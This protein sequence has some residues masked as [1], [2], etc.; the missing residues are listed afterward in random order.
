[1]QVEGSIPSSMDG[2]R[3]LDI[4]AKSS[5][6]Y[7]KFGLDEPPTKDSNMPRRKKL[8]FFLEMLQAN[9]ATSDENK[10][11]PLGEKLFLNRRY[12]NTYQHAM[13]YLTQNELYE[14]SAHAKGP[15]EY[16]KQN[17]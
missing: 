11:L 2:N 7:A 1:M 9:D 16:L 14:L 17:T 10:T 3:L 15:C 8:A 13:E 6:V 12:N 5:A 4:T